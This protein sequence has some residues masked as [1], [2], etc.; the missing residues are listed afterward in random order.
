L[1]SQLTLDLYR[2]SH[3][4][5]ERYLSDANL[6]IV[7]ALKDLHAVSAYSSI[8]LWGGRGTGKSHLLEAAVREANRL[9]HRAIYLPFKTILPDLEMILCDLTEVSL[10]A[11]DDVDICRGDRLNEERLFHFYNELKDRGGHMLFSSTSRPDT[12]GF[13][14]QDLAS[15]FREGLVYQLRELSDADKAELLVNEANARGFHLSQGTLKF[16]MQNYKRDMTSLMAILTLLDNASLEHSRSL[17]IPFV[18][19]LL[20][21]HEFGW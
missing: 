1:V 18:R 16:I 7:S 13:G 8:Y 21:G 10:V 11:I 3:H 19:K 12:A 4:E 14:L 5:F 6:E 17:T 9:K 15:R 2:A 20:D